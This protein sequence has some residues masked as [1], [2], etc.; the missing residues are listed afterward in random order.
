[1]RT[2]NGRFM[3]IGAHCG[4][5]VSNSD[6]AFTSTF[7]YLLEFLLGFLLHFAFSR[8]VF[9]EIRM[10]DIHEGWRPG[11]RLCGAD[12]ENGTQ[13]F[14]RP[15]KPVTIREIRATSRIGALFGSHTKEAI[16]DSGASANIANS[17]NYI[18]GACVDTSYSLVGV[19]GHGS[20]ISCSHSFFLTYFCAGKPLMEIGCHSARH[21]QRRQ[22]RWLQCTPRGQRSAGAYLHRFSY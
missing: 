22:T 11:V 13:H 2:E 20:K 18:R 17:L 15:G 3:I 16:L 9:S 14:R 12:F 5:F 19:N 8:F 4:A 1:M 7:I 21:R 10:D 6:T